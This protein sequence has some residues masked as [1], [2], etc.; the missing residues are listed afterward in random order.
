MIPSQ[1]RPKDRKTELLAVAR[2]SR[3]QWIRSAAAQSSA[4]RAAPA[5]APAPTPATGPTA[6]DVA[7]PG[8]A[9]LQRL[10]DFLTEV[11]AD[12][13]AVNVD[14]LLRQVEADEGDVED[15][16]VA[17]LATSALNVLTH[18]DDYTYAVFL[19]QLCAREAIDVVKAMQQFVT[20]FETTVRVHRASFDSDYYLN[21]EVMLSTP[22][23]DARVLYCSLQQ[24][25]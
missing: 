7:V 24:S 23:W 17:P 8:A 25:W 10:F 20:K 12:G 18:A 9:S 22:A 11:I 21:R 6:A 5:P 19:E 16:G 2:R 13:E 4:P 14:A 3:I 1:S 15:D